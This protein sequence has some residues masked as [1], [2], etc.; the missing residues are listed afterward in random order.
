MK[1][2]RVVIATFDPNPKVYKKSIRKMRLAG[3][4]VDAGFLEKEARQLNE[5][6][7]KNMQT[8]MPFVAVKLAQSLDG[9]IATA[10]GE[11]KWI[12][13]KASRSF[14]KCL[15]DKYDSVLVGINTVIK[16][17]PRLGGFKKIPYKVVIDPYLRLP[18][19]SYL[20]KNDSDKLIIFASQKKRHSHKNINSLAQVFF[21]KEKQGKLSVRNILKILYSLKIRS[22]FVEGGAETVGRFF[23]EELV[24]KIYLFIAPKII[25]GE[26]SLSAI[27]GKG[28]PYLNNCPVIKDICVKHIGEDLL[29]CGYPDY[30]KN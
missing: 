17:N 8:Q 23:D 10:K 12:T 1:M 5:V 25:G 11:S 9:K 6:F 26:G 24:D 27:K 20:L 22:V 4:K 13:Q 2:K 21:L 29:I 14:A 19:N 28:F 15:R 7:F 18:K 30:G 3:I 16:D